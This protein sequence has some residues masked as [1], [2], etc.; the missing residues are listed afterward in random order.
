MSQLDHEDGAAGFTSA[1]RLLTLIPCHRA[2]AKQVSAFEKSALIMI[3][4]SLTLLEGGSSRVTGH[5][6][7]PPPGFRTGVPSNVSFLPCERCTNSAKVVRITVT[8]RMRECLNA[9]QNAPGESCGRR[10]AGT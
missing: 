3:A 7:V 1:R 5:Q 4:D 2:I 8:R 10:K 9:L 6:P